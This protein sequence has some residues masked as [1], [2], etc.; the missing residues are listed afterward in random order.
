[1]TTTYFVFLSRIMVQIGDNIKA[2]F[3]GERSAL[4][5]FESYHLTFLEYSAGFGV[6]GWIFYV[7]VILLFFGL[8]GSIIAFFVLSLRR[9]ALRSFSKNASA[10]E[11]ED[12]LEK[13][14]MELEKYKADG[15]PIQSALPSEESQ[16][17]DNIRFPRLCH[18][19]DIYAGVEDDPL[20]SKAHISLQ[21]FCVNFKKYAA[22]KLQLFYTDEA[23]ISFVSSLASS[24]LIILEGFS[25]TGK[26]SLPYAFGEFVRTSASICPV[27]PSWRERSDLLGYYNEFTSKFSESSFLVSLY[28]AHYSKGPRL[29]VLDEMNLARVEY[30]FAEFLSLLE[31][32]SE[33]DKYISVINQPQVNDPKKFIEGRLTL[34]DNIYFVGTANNDEST[35]T[36]T[37]K[38]YDR[39]MSMTLEERAEPFEA[40]S[41]EA[42]PI[43]NE[44]LQLAFIAA[45]GLHPISEEIRK[46]MQN[47]TQFLANRLN[48]SFGNRLLRQFESYLP[49]FVECGGELM[50]GIDCFVKEKIL[51]KV[52]LSPAREDSEGLM[53]FEEF[54]NIEFGIE[55]LPRSLQKIRTV[56][57][58]SAQ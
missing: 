36:I 35:H 9:F 42:K 13:L 10:L 12:E 29:I 33:T 57:R 7:L 2:F 38:V 16:N 3:R 25:G 27:Q 30:Y 51:R 15:E 50:A 40:E 44:S 32:P 18:I 5:D 56:L 52:W 23:I 37:D 22:N 45:K 31:N 17:K 20:E 39:A 48:V 6:G 19:D 54:L 21:E 49:C 58:G 28:E 1:M 11:K 47:L 43:S 24:R 41:I 4:L 53:H 14:R 26:T 55:S 8:V 46:S 34:C